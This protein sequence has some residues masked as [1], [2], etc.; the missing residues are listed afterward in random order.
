MFGLW[1]PKDLGY[2]NAYVTYRLIQEDITGK[3]GETF[4]A[5]RL[6]SY[7]I[8][9]QEGAEN[10]VVYMGSLYRFDKSNVGDFKDEL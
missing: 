2:L 5:G 8:E 10:G 3:P 9:P 4:E 7:T 6:G 1:N